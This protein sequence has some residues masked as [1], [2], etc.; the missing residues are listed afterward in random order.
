MAKS[1]YASSDMLGKGQA[2]SINALAADIAALRQDQA[3][4]RFATC[5]IDGRMLGRRCRIGFD[6]ARCGGSDTAA[7]SA[8]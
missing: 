3:S 6:S 7:T 5:F 8:Q 4:D 2:A 1:R